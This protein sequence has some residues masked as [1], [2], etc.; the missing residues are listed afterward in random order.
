MQGVCILIDRFLFMLQEQRSMTWFRKQDPKP[1]GTYRAK[2]EDINLDAI[3]LE[4]GVVALLMS[5]KVSLSDNHRSAFL[6]CSCRSRQQR[7]LCQSKA[8]H[9]VSSRR[10]CCPKGV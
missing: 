9:G 1:T 10:V 3:A 7:S 8:K 6:S 4:S 5:A 2:N